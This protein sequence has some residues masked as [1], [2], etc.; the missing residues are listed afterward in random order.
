MNFTVWLLCRTAEGSTGNKVAQP[1]GDTGGALQRAFAGAEPQRRR[2]HGWAFE[3]GL[4]V[5]GRISTS[6]T[7]DT[8]Q[9]MQCAGNVSRGLAGS[10]AE[11]QISKTMLCA[12]FLL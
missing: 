6:R 5:M 11:V 2:L 4:G 10:G 3:L 9:G 7:G 8:S 1:A 12:S